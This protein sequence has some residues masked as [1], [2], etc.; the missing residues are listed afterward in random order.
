M[1][2]ALFL[3]RD[4][5]INLEAGY[6]HKPSEVIFVDGIFDLCA[7]AQNNCFRII[8]VT[9]QAGVAHGYYEEADVLALHAWMSKQFEVCGVHIDEFYYCPYHEEGAV[10]QYRRKT[11]DR[12]PGPGMLLKAR[13]QYQ[14][15]M[16][17]SVL[18]GD[19]DSDIDAAIAAGVG[20]QILLT[21]DPSRLSNATMVCS[22]LKHAKR[23]LF[24]ATGPA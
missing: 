11:P 22:S 5:I 10:E 8:V 2:R 13:D 9:N 6:V 24:T 3:D 18:V 12:K 17:A 16:A 23:F 14:I 4:G 15:D 1:N 21:D 7:A 19:K 20:R